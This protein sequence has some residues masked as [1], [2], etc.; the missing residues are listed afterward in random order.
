MPLISR[1]QDIPGYSPHPPRL[2]MPAPACATTN[3]HNIVPS[4][5]FVEY[6]EQLK[7]DKC[8]GGNVA[9][10]NECSMFGSS[11]SSD[12]GIKFWENIARRVEGDA[13]GGMSGVEARD[14]AQDGTV[15]IAEP[16]EAGNPRRLGQAE[17]PANARCEK[18]D[19]CKVGCTGCDNTT[20][21]SNGGDD[22]GGDE[23]KQDARDNDADDPTPPQ[24]SGSAD[25][26]LDDLISDGSTASFFASNIT[27]ASEQAKYYLY[28]LGDDVIA[29]PETH[30]CRKQTL[31]CL[32][33]LRRTGKWVAVGPGGYKKRPAEYGYRRA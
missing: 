11:K 29:A 2:P 5:S 19:C 24:P 20:R 8:A 14:P 33:A 17:R 31:R 18:T 22:G 32:R 3:Q 12:D 26:H 23:Q 27:Y 10:A 7:N 30:L 13:A 1:S 21:N 16:D 15:S 6:V 28:N 4:G 9:E 25:R